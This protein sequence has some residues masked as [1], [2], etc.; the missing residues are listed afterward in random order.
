MRNIHGNRI[1]NAAAFVAKNCRITRPTHGK[2]VMTQSLITG[3]PFDHKERTFA[4]M[5]LFVSA[6]Y[7]SDIS[8]CGRN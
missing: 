1:R 6:K 3:F 7:I 2:P 4:K 5:N 8:M